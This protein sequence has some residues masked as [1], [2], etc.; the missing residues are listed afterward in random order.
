MPD[1]RDD[2]VRTSLV[3]LENNKLKIKKTKNGSEPRKFRH[4]TTGAERTLFAVC[5]S[6]KAFRAHLGVEY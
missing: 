1:A 2:T 6:Y 4:E 5:R 3:S